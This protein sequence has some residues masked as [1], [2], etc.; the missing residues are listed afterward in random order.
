MLQEKGLHS[1]LVALAAL[2]CSATVDER[3]RMREVIQQSRIDLAQ[4]VATNQALPSWHVLK[5]KLP[6]LD[7]GTADRLAVAQPVD[8]VG[9]RP[10]EVERQSQ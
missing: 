9:G 2:G 10:G 7:E 3:A 8:Q 6:P 1:L 5:A 4:C